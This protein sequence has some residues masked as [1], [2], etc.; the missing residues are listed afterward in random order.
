MSKMRGYANPALLALG[1][2]AGTPTNYYE[3]ADC[4]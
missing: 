3:M 2:N 1:L 4:Q